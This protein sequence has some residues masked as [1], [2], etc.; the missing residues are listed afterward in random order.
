MGNKQTSKSHIEDFVNNFFSTCDVNGDGKIDLDEMEFIN[1]PKVIRGLFGKRAS[2]DKK[3]FIAYFRKWPEKKLREG[4]QRA[5]DMYNRREG[6]GVS[7]PGLEKPHEVLDWM[8]DTHWTS[9]QYIGI[10]VFNG[11]VTYQTIFNKGQG[12]V[13][14]VDRKV[15]LVLGSDKWILER[16]RGGGGGPTK[17]RLMWTKT[18]RKDTLMIWRL[19]NSFVRRYRPMFDVGNKVRLDRFVK[20]VV[21]NGHVGKITGMPVK[22]RWPVELENFTDPKTGKRRV[23]PIYCL[24]QNMTKL[25]DFDKSRFE[26]KR[27]KSSSEP[28]SFSYSTWLA[29]LPDKDAHAFETL[30][31]GQVPSMLDLKLLSREDLMCSSSEAATVLRGLVR[32][33]TVVAQL[34]F[35]A[36]GGRAEQLWEHLLVLKRNRF[37]ITGLRGST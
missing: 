2:V 37:R 33:D 12:D 3:R 22:N 34:G 20:T 27:A 1:D 11:K 13:R 18:E 30:F 25:Y 7:F 4:A 9:Q 21:L 23:K 15:Q 29:T 35:N 8:N 17:Q 6:K 24:E 14:V 26:R 16:A 31:E 28:Q 19:D 5:L 32:N 10:W 36:D